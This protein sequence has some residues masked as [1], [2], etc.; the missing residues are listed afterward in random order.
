MG[1]ALV[2]FSHDPRLIPGYVSE[3]VVSEESEPERRD[4]EAERAEHEALTVATPPDLS[5]ALFFSFSIF[6]RFPQ[7]ASG[8]SLLT[9]SFP[10]HVIHSWSKT[11]TMQLL[12][13]KEDVR[14]GDVSL[15]GRCAALPC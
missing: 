5:P 9:L 2:S 8:D 3:D 4:K 11:P 10:M 7:D 15:H 12:Y 6:L 1:V 14:T 13:P